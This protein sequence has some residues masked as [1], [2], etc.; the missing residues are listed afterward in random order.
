MAGLS[1]N[2]G[3][4][5]QWLHIERLLDAPDIYLQNPRLKC[6]NAN[7]RANKFGYHYF[8]WTVSHPG[9]PVVYWNNEWYILCHSKATRKLYHNGE[10][11]NIYPYIEVSEPQQTDTSKEQNDPTNE[12]IQN[13]PVLIEE[14][15]L[16][17]PHHTRSIKSE[18]PS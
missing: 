10:K 15:S 17:S 12:Q 9:T 3:G 13:A 16:G 5:K 14:D 6:I 1:S 8:Y 2:A 11:A 18:T 7:D 4:L